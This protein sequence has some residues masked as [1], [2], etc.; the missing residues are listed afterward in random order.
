MLSNVLLLICVA[1]F[2]GSGSAFTWTVPTKYSHWVKRMTPEL[3]T[4]GKVTSREIQYL[5]EA[6][7]KSILSISL[8]EESMDVY[9]GV[10]GPFPSTKEEVELA[11]KYNMTGM[12]IPADWSVESVKKVSAALIE[13]EKPIYVHCGVGFTVS[14]YV[15]LHLVAAGALP[16]SELYSST[17]VELGWDYQANEDAVTLVNAFTG[18]NPPSTVTGETLELTLAEQ[19]NSYRYFYWSHRLGNDTWYN[20][21]QPLD[22]QVQA[23]AQSGYKSVISFR[24]SGEP[25]CRTSSDDPEG[26]VNNGEF[27][28]ANGNYNATAEEEA[29]TG[30]GMKFF[31]LPVSGDEAFTAAQLDEYSGSIAAAAAA[32]PVLVHCASGYRSSA[33]M[34]AYLAKMLG[35]CTDWAVTQARRVGYSFDVSEDDA[36][37]MAFYESVLTC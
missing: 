5:S 36:A 29:V 34:T 8:Q 1:L 14:L 2:T 20:M 23:I 9:N 28:D 24:A 12:Y 30:A 11:R 10:P 17:K 6:G 18:M 15:A 31:N 33:Y 22:T 25:T 7:F 32:G 13:L 21:G 26:P 3:Y 19:E 4:G 16:E 35:Q 37:V 27:S